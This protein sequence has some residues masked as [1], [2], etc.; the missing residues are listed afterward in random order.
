MDWTF[1]VLNT[2]FVCFF[3]VQSSIQK[4]VCNVRLCLFLLYLIYLVDLTENMT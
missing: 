3:F 4:Y 2:I 1:C